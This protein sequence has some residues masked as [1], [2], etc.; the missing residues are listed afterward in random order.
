MTYFNTIPN[1]QENVAMC[2]TVYTLSP[3]AEVVI[4]GLRLTT[5]VSL[6][7]IPSLSMPQHS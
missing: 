3:A 1:L 7:K 2:L 6:I 4:P 5:H